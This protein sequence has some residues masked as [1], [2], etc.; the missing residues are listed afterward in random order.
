MQTRELS[1]PVPH[2]HHPAIFFRGRMSTDSAS[3]SCRNSRSE[4]G[5]NTRGMAGEKNWADMSTRELEDAARD[6]HDRPLGTFMGDYHV[7]GKEGPE[8][9]V[10]HVL[11]VHLE[12]SAEFTE[13]YAPSLAVS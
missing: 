12:S 3:F 11:C 2:F 13:S 6:N 4:S 1:S 7:K 8:E 9:G 5:G 10:S